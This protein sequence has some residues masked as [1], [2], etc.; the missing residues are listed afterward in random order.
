MTSTFQTPKIMP[1]PEKVTEP[2]LNVTFHKIT[3]SFVAAQQTLKLIP[4]RYEEEKQPVTYIV[5]VLRQQVLES[6]ADGIA[7]GDN[8]LSVE[9][10]GAGRVSQQCSPTDDGF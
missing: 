7:L 1:P 2:T 10:P 9:V 5:H 8:P 4:R 3:S 6:L